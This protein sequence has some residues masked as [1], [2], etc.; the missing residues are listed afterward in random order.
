MLLQARFEL[1]RQILWCVV[2][3]DGAA[4]LSAGTPTP[5][6]SDR[7][8]ELLELVL[9]RNPF[10]RARLEQLGLGG[11]RSCPT[12]RRSTKRELVEDQARH[13]PFGT[14][15][16]YPLERYTQ[17]YQTSGTT[18]PP[19]RVLDTAEDWAWWRE[20]FAHTLTV[21]GVGAGRPRGARLLVRPARAVLG[22]VPGAPG[23][24]R[25]GG[26]AR[27]HGLRAAPPDDRRDRGHGRLVHPHLRA[28]PRSRWPWSS[29]SSTRSS[30][31]AGDLHR[32]AGR[33]AARPCARA[34]RRASARAAWTTPG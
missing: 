28:A 30:R 29:G 6:A 34:S 20:R 7:L 18:G 8:G 17:L 2:C 11:R 12:C 32:R 22:R 25:D 9:E 16:T 15:L 14:N 26:G 10:Q 1:K 19:L 21:A 33:L 31:C 3:G 24:R 5:V 27:R 4:S 23:G 13:P